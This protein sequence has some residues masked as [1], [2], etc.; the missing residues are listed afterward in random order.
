MPV[1]PT[2]LGRL[3]SES[4]YDE[5]QAIRE[6]HEEDQRK[7]AAAN[8]TSADPAD[9]PASKMVTF[10]WFDRALGR[11]VE[12]AFEIRLLSFKERMAR[13]RAAGVMAGVPWGL[14]PTQTQ[15]YL[16]A[17]CTSQI[18]WPNASASW[19]RAIDDNENVAIS[20]YLAVEAH[21]QQYFRSNDAPSDPTEEEV[22]LEVL[23]VVGPTP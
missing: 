7:L 12:E 15:Q 20:A 23:P 16:L 1:I 14:L 18:M 4:A 11:K 9:T 8:S 22:E 6:K 13:S 10:R 3:E 5:A 19:R 2:T 21:R 17:V